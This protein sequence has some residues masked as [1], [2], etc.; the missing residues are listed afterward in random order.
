MGRI[1][2]LTERDLTRLVKRVISESRLISEEQMSQQE[3][4]SGL[5]D[6][7]SC[8]SSKNMPITYKLAGG[9]WDTAYAF[10][11]M[12]LGV[13]HGIIKSLTGVYMDDKEPSLSD[14]KSNIQKSKNFNKGYNTGKKGV[15]TIYKT[16]Y[17]QISG[18]LS[19]LKNCVFG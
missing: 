8:F 2:R 17:N 9:N 5:S 14:T 3:L 19:K 10:L 13:G 15:D 11:L 7:S 6:G 18:E 4:A 16:N 12:S 1:V